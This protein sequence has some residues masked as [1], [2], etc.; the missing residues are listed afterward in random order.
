MYI[1]MNDDKSLI[2]TVK[3]TIYRGEGN[4]DMI[5]FLIPKNYNGIN[6]ADCSVLMRYVEPDGNGKSEALRL[7][8]EMYKNYYQFSTVVDTGIT[9]EVGD[10]PV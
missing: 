4:A 5:T 1:K 2:I 10:I 7:V 9:K 8:P 3:T 6:I